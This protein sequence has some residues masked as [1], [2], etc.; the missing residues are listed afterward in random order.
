MKRFLGSC[1]AILALA[2]F[3]LTPINTTNAQEITPG[4]TPNSEALAT[5]APDQYFLGRV[6]QIVKTGQHE[7]EGYIQKYQVSRIL[8][9]SGVEKGQTIDIEHAESTLA[10]AP[11]VELGDRVV[12]VKITTDGAADYYLADKWRLPALGGL[13]V[14]FLLLILV[15]ARWQGIRSIIGLAISIGVIGWFVVPQ[16]IAG[17]NPILISII[18][19]IFIM[20]VSLYTAHGFNLRTSIALGSTAITF[21]IAAILAAI[22]VSLCQLFGLGSDDTL[23]LQL[24]PGAAINLKGLLLGGIILGT[25]G[26]LDDITT[27]QAA[28]VDEL[29]SANPSLNHQ[30]LYRRALSVGREHISSLVNTLFLAYAGAS[31]P[32]F[33]AIVVNRT[34]PLWTVINS[35]AV[36]EEIVRSLVGSITLVLAVP[37]TT[38]LAAAIISKRPPSPHHLKGTIHTH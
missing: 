25:L 20:L 19:A 9:T 8:I 15:L 35:E 27:A 33:L 13:L 6:E 22:A 31:L 26:V 12:I 14:A 24:A 7:T 23:T 30:E 28:V 32:L 21:V 18:G 3:F 11:K 34:Q 2:S 10:G 4:I 36:A 29:H 16:I 37:I 1:L 5:Y 38:A 17:Q